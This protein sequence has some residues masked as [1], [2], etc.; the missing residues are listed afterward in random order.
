MSIPTPRELGFPKKFDSWRPAQL[1]A[2]RLM[3]TSTK[4]VKAIEAPTGS[5]KTAIYVA[6]ALITKQPTC[7]VTES[8]GLMQQLMDDFSCVG[9]TDLKGRR[10]YPCDLKPGYTC[11]EGI[12]ARC[13]R[14]GSV[15]CPLSAAEF[16]A[17]T[18]LLV[19][20]NYDKWTSA[21]KFG[22]GMQHFTQVVFDEGHL[23]GDALGRAMQVILYEKEIGE[24]LGMD[25]P[26]KTDEMV[27]WRGWAAT[28][29]MEAEERTG[30]AKAQVAGPDPKAQWVRKLNHLRNLSKR[31]A[32]ISTCQP[33]HWVVDQI[34][35][36][37]QF[38]P[39]RVGRYGESALLLRI[40][41]IVVTSATLRPKSLFE[42]G[43]SRESTD[44]WDFPSDFN[45]KDCPIY[46][47]PT[48]RVDKNNP[49]LTMLWARHDQ[50]AA[51]RTDRKG[52]TH[53]ISYA[54]AS[55][56]QQ[57]SRFAHAMILNE[58]GEPS[59][60]TVEHF[61]QSGPGTIL[62]SPSVGAG[63]DFPG[64]DCEWQFICKIPFPDSRSKIVRARQEDDKEWGPSRA[65]MKLQQIFGR[66]ARFKGDRCENVIGDM[67][68]EWFIP[69]YRHLFSKSFHAFF[70]RVEVLPQPPPKL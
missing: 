12:A 66:G 13:P 50:I 61:K 46:Y 47:V 1:E 30:V 36:G 39:V 23:A 20:T 7:F 31:L 5:G 67:H 42:I 63:F 57:K 11:E 59:T 52:I 21:R 27:D 17:G 60:D 18:S 44:Y 49:D 2:I 56:I 64:R 25:F 6:Y 15:A 41:S 68:V 45:P 16:K 34:E 62:V 10:R 48:M 37:Y 4:R 51:R 19:S 28:A 53:T 65:A 40:P 32:T 69:R 43:I 22:Q 3:L 55:D 35:K 29:R 24:L 70:K 8:L 54:R 14:R 33:Q 38:D 9:M 58:R 26:R